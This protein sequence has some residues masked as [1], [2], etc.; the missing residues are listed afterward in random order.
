MYCQE[1]AVKKEEASDSDDNF[2]DTEPTT[3]SKN[4]KLLF[5]F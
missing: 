2:D 3:A 4:S 1:S 5:A